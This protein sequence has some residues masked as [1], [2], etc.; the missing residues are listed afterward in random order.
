MKLTYPKDSS[1]IKIDDYNL[2]DPKLHSDGDVHLVWHAM[3]ERAPI[4]WTETDNGLGF[5]SVTKYSDVKN[6]LSNHNEFTSERGTLLTLLGTD[7]PASGK[8]VTVT[9]PPRHAQ[10]RR[11]MQ[12]GFAHNS[13]AKHIDVIKNEVRQLLKPALEGEV[14]DFAQAMFALSTAVAG[15]ILGLPASDWPLITQLTAMSIAPDDPKYQLPEGPQA[16][17]Q[18]AHREIFSY[19]GDLIMEKENWEDDEVLGILLHQTVDDEPLDFGGILANCYALLLGSTVTTPHVP[20]ATLYTLMECGGYQEWSKHPEFLKSGIEEGLRWS[21]PAS[22]IMRY[23]LKD[24][25]IRG[26]KIKKGEA[27]VSWISSANRDEEVFEDPYTF[28]FRR[29]KNPHISFGSG[30]HYC[31]GHLAARQTLEILFTE[32]FETFEGF[33]LCGDVEHLSS[34]FIGGLKHFPIRGKVKHTVRV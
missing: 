13:L 2:A 6:V 18:H 20:S 19:F 4:H 30:I 25:E 15:A 8:Q 5:W 16:T 34:N 27:V 21:S 33:E 32:L 10:L 24:T 22:H 23:A 9:D 28:N 3:R 31:M 26:Q 29:K 17:L 1:H 14:I 12:K 7:D 11:P